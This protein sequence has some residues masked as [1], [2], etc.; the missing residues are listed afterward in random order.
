MTGSAG[1]SLLLFIKDEHERSLILGPVSTLK[2][3]DEGDFGGMLE[4]L[5]ESSKNEWLMD[6]PLYTWLYHQPLQE[7]YKIH[8]PQ[9]FSACQHHSPDL[10]RRLSPHSSV[11]V[12]IQ[13]FIYPQQ[14]GDSFTPFITTRGTVLG[15]LQT[16]CKV[17]TPKPKTGWVTLCFHWRIHLDCVLIHKISWKSN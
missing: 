11:F 12:L 7:S 6:A 9:F 3:V 17:V 13:P 16:Q 2:G 14:Q 4:I 1:Q 8:D 5:W 10:E 15:C